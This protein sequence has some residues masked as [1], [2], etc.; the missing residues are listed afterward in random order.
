MN[1]RRPFANLS[2]RAQILLAVAGLVLAA[3]AGYFVLISPARSEAAELDVEIAS[4]EQQI[5]DRRATSTARQ[6]RVAVKTADLF[7]L[8]KA[9]P[10]DTNMASVILELN[11]IA[12]ETGIVFD[13]ITPQAPVAQAQYSTVPISLSFEGNFYTLS[14]FLF[15]LRHLVQVRD[16]NL[17]TTGR[18][19]GVDTLTFSEG[20]NGFPQIKAALTVNAFVFG[21]Q[22]APGVPGTEPGAAT[23][24]T[25]TT[26]TATTTT[27]PPTPAPTPSGG[28]TAAPGATNNPP[29]S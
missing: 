11:R 15:R 22:A 27:T 10:D 9:M 18:L 20:D 16:G 29:S 3:V 2:S 5:A 4:V 1:K 28:A 13:S 8:A 7:R 21:A 25:D 6:T 19:F 24:S 17:S 14:D 26:Q 23:T 12:A